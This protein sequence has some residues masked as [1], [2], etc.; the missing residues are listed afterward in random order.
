MKPKTHKTKRNLRLLLNYSEFILEL[1][2]EF[3]FVIEHRLYFYFFLLL[4]QFFIFILFF[5]FFYSYL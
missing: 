5:L 1:F 4:I 3:P 2:L